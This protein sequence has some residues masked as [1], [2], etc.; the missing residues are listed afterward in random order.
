MKWG[1]RWYDMVRMSVDDRFYG[2]NIIDK[3]SSRDLTINKLFFIRGEHRKT[4]LIGVFLISV[5]SFL[6]YIY[7]RCP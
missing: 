7:A 2:I 5:H 3:L 6:H 4:I 1:M